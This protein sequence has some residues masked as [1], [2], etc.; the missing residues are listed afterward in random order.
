[1]QENKVDESIKPEEP[2]NKSNNLELVPL[3]TS[4]NK[5]NLSADPHPNPTQGS[6]RKKKLAS[7]T[8]V[9]ASSTVVNPAKINKF[10]RIW[11]LIQV[12]FFVFVSL[13]FFSF[14]KRKT[15]I[16]LDNFY[17]VGF[18]TLITLYALFGDD[19]RVLSTDKV[20]FYLF[21][22]FFFKKFFSFF[23]QFF[24]NSKK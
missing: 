6:V 4:N 1:M 13:N 22:F 14:L 2:V 20:I 21:Q 9:A 8:R 19:I 5:N 23:C 11:H 16:F 3:K 17:Y 24:L 18:M 7:D 12:F 15:A 10:K